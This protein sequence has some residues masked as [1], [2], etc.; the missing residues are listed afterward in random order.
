[1]RDSPQPPSR[2]TPERQ[3]ELRCGPKP[4][5]PHAHVIV[6]LVILALVAMVVVVMVV[7]VVEEEVVVVRQ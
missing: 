2:T 1:M 7:V 5:L 6:A 3:V 4:P